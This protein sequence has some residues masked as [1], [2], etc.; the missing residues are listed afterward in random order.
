MWQILLSWLLA[1]L[2]SGIFHW[3]EDK[4]L[5]DDNKFYFLRQLSIANSIHHGDPKHMLSLSLWQNMYL[6]IIITI[7]LLCTLLLMRAPDILIM[8]IFFVSFSNITHRFS[9]IPY[10]K[11]NL[12]IRFLQD[13][14]VFIASKHHAQHHYHNG[15]LISKEDSFERYCTMTNWLNPL[16]DEIK[17]FKGLESLLLIFNIKTTA[18][19]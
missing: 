15:E 16:L 5:V 12:L 3:V 18:N 11:N 6:T 10:S 14:G 1:D 4:Y 7:P 17:F 13:T 2:L 19:K 9:H 8:V